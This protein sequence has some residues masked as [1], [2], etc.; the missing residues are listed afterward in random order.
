MR[1]R[2]RLQ[3]LG[4]FEAL[5]RSPWFKFGEW[6]KIGFRR[7]DDTEKFVRHCY[8]SG[9]VQGEFDWSAWM[10]TDE[11]QELRD[12][13]NIRNRASE[14]QLEK[15]LTVAIRQD[16][17]VE[18]GLLSWFENGQLLAIIQRADKLRA[19]DMIS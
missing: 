17:F 1:N 9:W 5:F 16:R 15:L 7:S 3:A 13:D 14:E 12:P 6:D 4:K 19:V 8:D 18:G 10:A 11:A 2:E